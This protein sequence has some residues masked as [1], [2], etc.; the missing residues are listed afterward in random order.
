VLWGL[1]KQRER[2]K[3]RNKEREIKMGAKNIPHMS[4]FQE[5]YY[6]FQVTN[7]S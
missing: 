3:G 2:N 1:V 4:T 5:N 6:R 7:S